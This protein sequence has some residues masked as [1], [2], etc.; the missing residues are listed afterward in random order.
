MNFVKSQIS[1]QSRTGHLRFVHIPRSQP[2]ACLLAGPQRSSF[3][4]RVSKVVGQ[5]HFAKMSSASF[6]VFLVYRS[7]K[8]L[9]K[10]KTTTY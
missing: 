3:P 10:I 9:N 1:T 8:Q 4:D 2:V 7:Q 6:L 5:D